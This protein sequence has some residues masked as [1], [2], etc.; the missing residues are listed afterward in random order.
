MDCSIEGCDKP[1]RAKGWCNM[2]YC[3][4][5]RHGDTHTVKPSGGECSV[6]G[7]DLPTLSRGWCRIHYARWRRHGD[8]VAF[9]GNQGAAEARFDDY[10]QPLV[11]TD[12]IVWTGSNAR[13]GYGALRVDGRIVP[14]HRYAW[15]RENG[16]IPDGM[17]VDHTCWNRACVNVDHLRLASPQQNMQNRSGATTVSATGVRGVYPMRDKY[18][19]KV[20]H[21]G[22]SHYVGTYA[23]VAEAAAAVKRK[24]KELFGEY[25]GA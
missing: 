16:P 20:G 4:W 14:A 18:Q 23:T 22:V 24:R 11:W 10:S 13:G 2:H 21:R 8:P 25:A 6:G 3:R 1:A 12:C 17:Y 15:Q 9:K 19:A 5:R 7:C